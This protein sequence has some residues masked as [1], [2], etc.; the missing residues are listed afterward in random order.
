MFPY[1]IQIKRTNTYERQFETHKNTK[2][3]QLIGE[4]SIRFFVA[5]KCLCFALLLFFYF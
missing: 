1:G 5:F 3:E 2:E 4:V